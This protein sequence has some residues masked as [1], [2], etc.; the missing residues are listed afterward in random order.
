MSAPF[1][2]IMFSRSWRF[3][4]FRHFASV[5]GHDESV[6]KHYLVRS[7]PTGR[8]AV[9]QGGLEPAAMLVASLKVHISGPVEVFPVVQDCR[10]A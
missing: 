1:L 2:S 3:E 8:Y 10:V 4:R 5:S 6:S 9:Q 7:C